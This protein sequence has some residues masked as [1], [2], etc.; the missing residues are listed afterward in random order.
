MIQCLHF[1]M[2]V[3]GLVL[4]GAGIYLYIYKSELLSYVYS[5]PL[6]RPACIIIITVGSA[7][8]IPSFCGLVGAIRENHI[9][10]IIASIFSG[11]C[12]L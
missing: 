4:I 1:L 8:I 11:S 9:L 6:A 3:A 10:L 5:M 12:Y 2:K 7:V